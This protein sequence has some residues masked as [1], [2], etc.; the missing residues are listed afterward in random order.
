MFIITDVAEA[1]KAEFNVPLVL[2]L[3]HEECPSTGNCFEQGAGWISQG[4]ILLDI[5]KKI[6][7]FFFVNVLIKT[8]RSFIICDN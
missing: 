6:Q 5:L 2:Y 8:N 7:L 3:C 1:L 4:M